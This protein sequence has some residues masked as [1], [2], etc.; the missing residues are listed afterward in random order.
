MTENLAQA[1]VD[2]FGNTIPSWLT[3]FI[4]SMFPI[5]ELRGGLIAASLLGVPLVKAFII[6]YIGN[7]LPIPF[8]LLLIKK[9]FQWMRRFPKFAK[10]VDKMESKAE[11]GRDRVEKYKEWGLFAF[12]AIPLP[13]TGGWTGALI[14]AV[15]NLDI[16]KSFLV[17][18]LGVL[19]AGI[20]M[21]LISYGIPALIQSFK[22]D[23]AVAVA[24]AV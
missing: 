8:I 23:A 10:I 22:A 24:F 21:A 14:S 6:C 18:A 2:F 19:T 11:K 4:I 3:I 16:K 12:V 7:L 1:L 15:L 5:L 17:I 13:G 20:I 9:I